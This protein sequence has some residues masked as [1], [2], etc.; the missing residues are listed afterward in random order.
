MN[1]W[2]SC[3]VDWALSEEFL[4]KLK[5]VIVTTDVISSAQTSRPL[6]L[7]K[8]HELLLFNIIGENS[9]QHFILSTDVVKYIAESIV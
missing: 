8:K 5:N 4:Q 1:R 2:P 7:K 3:V 6:L 9:H